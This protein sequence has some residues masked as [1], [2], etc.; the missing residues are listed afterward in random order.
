MLDE[1]LKKILL[2]MKYD[3]KM[4]L[5]ENHNLILFEQTSNVGEY[6]V[7]NEKD[8]N[9]IQLILHPVKL[10]IGIH[11]VSGIK[12]WVTNNLFDLDPSKNSKL[13]SVLSNVFKKSGIGSTLYLKNE[14]PEINLDNG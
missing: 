6:S 1:L 13:I 14:A 12:I 11:Q 7:T 9:R 5:N 2:N 10:I 8:Y 3:P 4:S